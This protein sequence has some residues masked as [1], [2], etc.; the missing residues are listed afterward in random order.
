MKSISTFPGVFGV[1]RYAEAQMLE[2]LPERKGTFNSDSFI[3][4]K[5]LTVFFL[6]ESTFFLLATSYVQF[7][8]S[9][10]I[11]EE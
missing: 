10:M 7:N 8:V 6:V 9:I 4:P 2:C 3:N 5:G 1:A 11:N